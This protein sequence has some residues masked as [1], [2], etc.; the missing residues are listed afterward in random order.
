MQKVLLKTLFF[1]GISIYLPL[2]SMAWGML[3]HRI[4]G[5]IA[6]SYLTSKAKAAI[7]KILGVE[8]MA[9]ASNWADFVKSDSLYKYLDAWHYIDFADDMD[10]KAMKGYL[11]KDTAADAY[12]ALNFL[13]RELKKKSLP[14]DK[15]VMYL[16]LLIH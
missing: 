11:Q 14:Q 1:V 16:R 15:K 4:V 5:E 7:Q 13:T 8:S 6:E 3:G 9:M 10:Y 12:R 2:Q